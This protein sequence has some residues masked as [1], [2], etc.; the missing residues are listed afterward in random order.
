[1]RQN[2]AVNKF[3]TY[4]IGIHII[5]IGLAALTGLITSLLTGVLSYLL[6]I[7]ATATAVYIKNNKKNRAE[8][9]VE[10]EEKDTGLFRIKARKRSRQVESFSHDWKTSDDTETVQTNLKEI[11]N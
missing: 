1:M 10:T 9:E 5:S 2:P 8:P 7:H 3:Y 11:S 4:F 6:Y